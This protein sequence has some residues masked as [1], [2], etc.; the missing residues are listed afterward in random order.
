MLDTMDSS[1]KDLAHVNNIREIPKKAKNK[2]DVGSV[3]PTA[4]GRLQWSSMR[5][6]GL[7]F[8]WDP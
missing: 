5:P 8:P 1:G 3:S 7:V 6:G 2:V 4:G